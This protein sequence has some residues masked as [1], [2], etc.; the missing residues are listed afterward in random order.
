MVKKSILIVEDERVSATDLKDTL[1]S[2]GYEVTGIA[3]SGE[4]AIRMVDVTIPDLILM[5]IRLSGKLTGI[6]AAEQILRNHAIPII[7]LTAYADPDLVERAKL[8]KPY[9]YLLKPYDERGIRTEIEIALYKF[10]LDQD[11]QREYARLEQRVM[12]RTGELTR[13]NAELKKSETRYR[14]LFERSGEGIFIIDAGKEARG[15]IAEVNTAGAVMHGYPQE[16]LLKMKITDLALPENLITAP[17]QFAAILSGEWIEGEVSHFR[18]D[19]SVFPIDF[20]ACL[21]ELDGHNCIYLVIRDISEQKRIRDEIVKARDEWELTFNAVTDLIAIIDN[22]FR[23]VR[24][25]RAMA[26]RLG[27][28]PEKAVGHHC[29]EAVHNTSCPPDLCPHRLLLSDGKPHIVDIHE[30]HL[31]GDFIL[32]V[33]PVLDP[34]GKV[35]GSVHVLHDITGRKHAEEALKESEKKYRTIL[36]NMQDLFYRTDLKGKITMINAAGARFAGYASPDEL[37]GMDA[38][39]MYAEP[40]RR[41]QFLSDLQQKGALSE[42]PL[43]LRVRDGSIRYATTNSHFYCDA[44]GT[45]IGVEGII[46]DITSL[47]QTKDA[48]RMANKKLN[49]LSSITRHDIRNQ[50]QALRTYIQLSDLVSNPRQLAEYFRK[51]EIIADNIERQ[52]SFTHDYEDMGIKSPIWQ[53]VESIV[54]TVAS[55]LPVQNIRIEPVC[56]GLEIFADPL[57]EKVFYNLIDNALRYG[58]PDMTMIRISSQESD[59]GVVITVEDNGAGI[60]AEYKKRLFERGFGHHTGL[61]LFLS[62]EILSIT[63]ITIT[64]NSEPGKGARFEILVPKGGY[65]FTLTT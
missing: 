24:M 1:I 56:P 36:E 45:I 23:I 35:S 50:L 6:D 26:D 37:I 4:Q 11:L 17:T 63:G 46:H 41:E 33:A 58:G 54:S 42:Y 57:L 52:I 61:G 9:G 13:I 12:E 2:F 8:T 34:S 47:Q 5:D 7:Y 3:V 15:R 19:G 53:S 43:T 65:Q 38:T 39:V 60:S 21:V 16:E 48:L 22:N 62:R 64:G 55:V 59:M 31:N 30:D 29:Y 10:G 49:L 40:K 32:S 25:N 27:T 44:H 51:E 18:K 28:S 14:L 20:R